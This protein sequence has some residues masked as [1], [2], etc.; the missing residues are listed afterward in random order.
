MG[1]VAEIVEQLAMN[2]AGLISSDQ[3]KSADGIRA[4]WK[5]VHDPDAL[6]HSTITIFPARPN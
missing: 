4:G 5:I 2:I 1:S 3:S 6:E